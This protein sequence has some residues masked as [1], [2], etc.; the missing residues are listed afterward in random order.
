MELGVIIQDLN[1]AIR[2]AL[3]DAKLKDIEKLC[4]VAFFIPV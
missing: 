4:M 1:L 3:Q 2:D